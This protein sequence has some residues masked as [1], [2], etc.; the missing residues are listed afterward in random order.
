MIQKSKLYKVSS[1]QNGG[2]STFG[3]FCQIFGTAISEFSVQNSAQKI[4]QKTPKV[5]QPPFW[6]L[7]M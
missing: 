2:F 6:I 5:L 7:L 4:R 1:M 3:V